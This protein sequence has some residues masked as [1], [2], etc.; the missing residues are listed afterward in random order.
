MKQALI[1]DTVL[2]F[3]IQAILSKQIEVQCPNLAINGPRG[4]DADTSALPP[5]AGLLGSL[6][7]GPVMTLSGRSANEHALVEPALAVRH[8]P[9]W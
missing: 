3:I 6:G 2:L 4:H 9:G 7:E 1:F 5:N 8:F